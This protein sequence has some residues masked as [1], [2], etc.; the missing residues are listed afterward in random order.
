MTKIFCQCS[1]IYASDITSSFKTVKIDCARST[2]CQT[3]YLSWQS[4]KTYIQGSWFKSHVRVTWSLIK[5]ISQH[6]VLDKKLERD[7]F[8][9]TFSHR[10]LKGTFEIHKFHKYFIYMLAIYS[11]AICYIM[12]IGLPEKIKKDRAI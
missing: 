6:E 11:N 5:K 4:I 1:L 12:R 7:D 2:F 10:Y 3:H 8:K 9:Y